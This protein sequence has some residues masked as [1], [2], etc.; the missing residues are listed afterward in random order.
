[1]FAYSAITH[2]KGLFFCCLLDA[3]PVQRPDLPRTWNRVDQDWAGQQAR[4]WPR[5]TVHFPHGH[6]G[7]GDSST[8][9][10]TGCPIRPSPTITSIITAAPPS[11]STHVPTNTSF[12][13]QEHISVWKWMP[14]HD[15]R[16][17]WLGTFLRCWFLGEEY[18]TTVVTQFCVLSVT[19]QPEH[20]CAVRK[21]LKWASSYN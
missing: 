8:R 14:W 13:K 10:N 20:Q 1:M 5:D 15:A 4:R 3:R 7:G 21:D 19:I 11:C 9:P 6:G 17:K 12:T 16:H 2:G 18:D